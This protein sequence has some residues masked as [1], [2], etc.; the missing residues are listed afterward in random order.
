MGADKGPGAMLCPS[1]QTLVARDARDCPYCKAELRRPFQLGSLSNLFSGQQYFSRLFLGANLLIYLLLVV[2]SL[3]AGTLVTDQ[4]LFFGAPGPEVA[5][6]V[7]AVHPHSV[8]VD[9]Q[10]WRLWPAVFLHFSVL[11]VLLVTSWLRFSGP[12]VEYLVGPA[13]FVII[14]LV[15]GATS[16]ASAVRFAAPDAGFIAGGSGACFGLLATLIVFGLRHRGAFRA[17]LRREIVL[18]LVF[19]LILGLAMPDLNAAHL[20]GFVSGAV[21]ALLI[22]ARS[23]E[24]PLEGRAIRGIAALLLLGFIGSW[25]YAA[26]AGGRYEGVADFERQHHLD[27]NL[28]LAMATALPAVEILAATGGTLPGNP[29]DIRR[30]WNAALDDLVLHLHASQ[31]RLAARGL[32][33]DREL[34]AT[35]LSA[36]SSLVASRAAES[37][38][39]NAAR[40]LLPDLRRV[41]EWL[42]TAP[43]RTLR[44]H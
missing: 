34:L 24:R 21:V 29:D 2:A 25:L 33:V 19:G 8:R 37:V 13:R 11:H 40:E 39:S 18:W 27:Q 41:R 14:Y 26:A 23:P 4:L 38:V 10:W 1:C 28:P 35:R 22:G 16:F 31:A 9:G 44:A 36:L 42:R 3:R 15:C 17:E 12:L 6:K 7:G 5:W 32:A 20:G 30:D 43:A